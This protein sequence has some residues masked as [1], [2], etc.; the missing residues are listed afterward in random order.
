MTVVFEERLHERTSRLLA[1]A[2]TPPRITPAE[3]R[4]QRLHVLNQLVHSCSEVV[5]VIHDGELLRVQA[6]A[7]LVPRLELVQT[8][9]EIP[10]EDPQLLAYTLERRVSEQVQ[11]G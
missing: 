10:L 8:R 9:R 2:G 5:G 6:L 7:K 3:E 11:D 4:Q 1:L